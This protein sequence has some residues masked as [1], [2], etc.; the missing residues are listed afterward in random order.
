MFCSRETIL[1]MQN[2]RCL[3]VHVSSL[4]QRLGQIQIFEQQRHR[5]LSYPVGRGHFGFAKVVL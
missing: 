1:T 3:A 2:F 5:V 4:V